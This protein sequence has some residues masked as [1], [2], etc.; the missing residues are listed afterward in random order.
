VVYRVETIEPAHTALLVVD[1]QNDFIGARAP[2]ETP[3]GRAMIPTLQRALAFARERG[4]PVVYTAH[5]HR[6]D[7]SDMGLYADLVPAIADG[8]ALV[9]GERGA[10][11]SD[12][13]APLPGELV[14]KK[15]RYSAFFGT[16]LEIVLR[17]LGVRTVVVTGVTTECCVLA[18]ARDAMFRDF[19]TIVLSDACATCDFPDRGQ[20]ELSAADA[21]RAMLVVLA[22]STADVMTTDELIS[23]AGG[24]R[25]EVEWSTPVGR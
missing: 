11:I 18:T 1:M 9:D 23:R 14:V 13:V 15:H 12:D 22:A 5:V 4:M 24:G 17:G 6:R 16:D 7:G 21:H 20:G 19:A 2:L 10:E 3:A 25:Q 8:T